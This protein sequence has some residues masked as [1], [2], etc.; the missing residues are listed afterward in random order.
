MVIFSSENDLL[1]KLCEHDDLVRACVAGEVRFETFCD[2][3][4]NFYCFYALDGHESDVEE[5][6]LLEKYEDRIELHRAI[7]EEILGRLCSEVDAE[8]EIYR[9]AGR[10]GAKEALRRL[11]KIQLATGT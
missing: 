8:R 2:R 11:A 4:N 9:E 10:F 1:Q 7:A 5:R 3:Y 6:A